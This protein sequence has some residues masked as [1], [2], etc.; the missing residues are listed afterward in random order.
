LADCV[1]RMRARLPLHPYQDERL[2]TKPQPAARQPPQQII[3][4][5]SE[6]WAAPAPPGGPAIHRLPAPALRRHGRDDRSS[7]PRHFPARS[8]T[9]WPISLALR[10]RPA[11]PPTRLRAAATSR[12]GGGLTA[13][14]ETISS[15]T[16]W[17]FAARPGRYP[18]LPAQRCHGSA[19]QAPSPGRRPSN[20]THL[21]AKASAMASPS[22]RWPS[23]TF[24][25]CERRGE[26]CHTERGQR[27]GYG[28]TRVTWRRGDEQAG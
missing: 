20:D 1:E 19:P 3:P 13:A 2:G 15:S 5:P 28:R 24:P 25:P 6:G 7:E 4:Q 23:S 21:P 11:R 27:I 14:V 10:Q 12:H 18:Q 26:A 17:R 16:G 8:C 22:A 9:N